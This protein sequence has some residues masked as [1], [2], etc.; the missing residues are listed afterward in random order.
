MREKSFKR[1][2]FDF[3][4]IVLG[5]TVSF[6]FNQLSIKRSDNKERIKVLNNIEK[7]IAEIEKY[8]DERLNAWNDDIGCLLYTSPSPRDRQ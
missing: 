5:I 3:I 2:L 7:E 8:C 1:Y 4:V 6:W